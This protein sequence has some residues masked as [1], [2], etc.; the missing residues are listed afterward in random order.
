[1]RVLFARAHKKGRILFV[2][3]VILFGVLG[4]AN[5]RADLGGSFQ[6]M[7]NSLLGLG[8]YF[9][10]TVGF[11]AYTLDETIPSTNQPS[12]T[13]I[14]LLSFDLVALTSGVLFYASFPLPLSVVQT[15][16]NV[17]TG[18]T[19]SDYSYSG[20]LNMLFGLGGKFPVSGDLEAILGGGLSL[21]F[22][23]LNSKKVS[24]FPS[25]S[26]LDLGIGAYVAFRF[27][28]VFVV[29]VKGIYDISRLSNNGWTLKQGFSVDPT[30][31][32]AI[33]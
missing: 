19:V 10:V 30:V 4:V 7:A 33:R 2:L 24:I 18:R 25:I 6:D 15:I 31:G 16:N 5:A 29:Q 3:L 17:D 1:M 12:E 26:D 20:I 14:G 9:G 22:L 21:Y 32:I 28:D 23:N 27:T 11:D 13:K 8:G